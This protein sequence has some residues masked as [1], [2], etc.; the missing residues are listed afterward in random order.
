MDFLMNV[1]VL[2]RAL[3][4][5][6]AWMLALFV[7]AALAAIKATCQSHKATERLKRKLPFNERR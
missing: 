3:A 7:P 5:C 1:P 2:G 4:Y 6:P